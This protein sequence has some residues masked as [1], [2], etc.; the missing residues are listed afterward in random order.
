MLSPHEE[1]RGTVDLLHHEGSVE[2]HDRDMFGGLLDLRDLVVSDV[3]I[4]R[5]DMITV[6][7]DDPAEDIIN[8]VLQSPVTR[9]PLWSGKPENIIGILHAKDLLRAIQAANDDLVEDRREGDRAA[10]LVRARHPPAVRAAQGVP[11]P[12]HAVRARGRR[13]RRGD[14]PGDA[15]RHS[16]GDRRRHHR[17]ARRRGARRAAAARRLG[18]CRRRRADPRPQPRHGL[19]PARRRRQPPSRASSSTRRARSPS[20]A[21]PSRSTASAFACCA[22]TATASPRCASRPWQRRR[23]RPLKV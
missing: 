22:A 21:R 9:V 15:G 3:M 11:P 7:A 4:H 1:L 19:E 17:R 18:Q 10:A 6:C 20:R 23:P 5:T 12:P 8:E 13:I 16:G 2:K 14:G